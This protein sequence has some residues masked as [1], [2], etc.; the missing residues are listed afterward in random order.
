MRRRQIKFRNQLKP[1][2]FN[3]THVSE[4]YDDLL[5]SK[6]SNSIASAKKNAQTQITFEHFDTILGGMILP[7]FNYPQVKSFKSSAKVCSVLIE[8]RNLISL[9]FT[10]KNTISKLPDNWAHLILC[11]NE[12]YENVKRIAGDISD[13]IEVR[14]CFSDNITVSQYN[15]YLL[16]KEFWQ[17]FTHEFVLT[18]Q[19]D[20]L[21]T[22]AKIDWDK[23]FQYGFT[24]A[25]N[26]WLREWQSTI[27]GKPMLV[28]NGGFSLRNVQMCIDALSDN[29]F[30][31]V[32]RYKHKHVR[33]IEWNSIYE[34]V[35]FS[36]YAAI[37]NIACPVDLALDFSREK[38]KDTY[39]INIVE[40][41][42]N[43][44]KPYLYF[45][46][47]YDF[48]EFVRYKV[49]PKVNKTIDVWGNSDITRQEI[50]N[51][52]KIQILIKNIKKQLRKGENI[53]YD[54][55]IKYVDRLIATVDPLEFKRMDVIQ[56][57]SD[58]PYFDIFIMMNEN[59]NYGKCKKI[60]FKVKPELN[61]GNMCFL[62][63]K[64][65][66]V[67]A[68]KFVQKKVCISLKERV[69]RQ[70]NVRKQF[71]QINLQVDFKVVNKHTEQH[72][73]YNKDLP[74]G[75]NGV[76]IN[77]LEVLN[78]AYLE[79]VP[80]LMI[81]E[82]DCEFVPNF[83]LACTEFL[84]NVPENWD[85]I[86]LGGRERERNKPERIVN[87]WV[88]VPHDHYGCH[89]VIFSRKGIEK[90]V[91]SMNVIEQIPKDVDIYYARLPGL[92]QYTNRIPL[93]FQAFSQSNIS[94]HY[95][96]DCYN[97]LNFAGDSLTFNNDLK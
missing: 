51:T 15:E 4:N 20:C 19:T 47:E 49:L 25:T 32:R 58:N 6:D 23:Y 33:N 84:K 8:T 52:D 64:N 86:W 96:H 1:N 40:Q 80:H 87:N 89:S 94:N 73:L 30:E 27:I 38:T 77:H 22:N 76:F 21:V 16:S 74:Q 85:M 72:F 55:F 26:V 36:A 48:E 66:E 24:G 50:P 39:S 12:N 91:E 88:R 7:R 65:D 3:Q 69:D 11:G 67:S 41:V 93:T 95:Y 61:Y 79:G 71:E 45:K 70:Y 17:Q 54:S 63:N 62:E 35:F 92:I 14:K 83:N 53:Y 34:D 10:I 37:K 81:F 60:G 57:C 82:D 29:N 28:G 56:V 90:I 59:P 46:T 78:Q 9:E 75:V 18:Y 68:L 5:I 2:S 42:F 43:Y 44:H 13:K 97:T 31:L